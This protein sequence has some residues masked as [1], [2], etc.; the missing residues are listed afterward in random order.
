LVID[1][2]ETLFSFFS[3]IGYEFTQIKRENYNILFFHSQDAQRRKNMLLGIC[4]V[5]ALKGVAG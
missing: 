4:F 1:Q 3:Y 2:E 5:K